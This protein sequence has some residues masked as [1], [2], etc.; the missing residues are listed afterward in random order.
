VVTNNSLRA[1]AVYEAIY[2]P[3]GRVELMIKEHKRHLKLDR[4]SCHRFEANQFR[5]FFHCAAYDLMYTLL[6]NLLR[7]T[8]LARAQFDTIRLRLLKIGARV[9][10]LSRKIIFHLPLS[11]PLKPVLS[12]CTVILNALPPIRAG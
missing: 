9:Q 11:S 8:E 10:V 5:L 1:K 6:A 3:R 12:R 4:T 2:C 7:G